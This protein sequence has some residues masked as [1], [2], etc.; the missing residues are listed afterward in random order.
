MRRAGMHTSASHT[1]SICIP[2]YR[3]LICSLF[4]IVVVAHIPLAANSFARGDVQTLRAWQV[5]QKAQAARRRVPT[6]GNVQTRCLVAGNQITCV[7]GIWLAWQAKAWVSRSFYLKR[8]LKNKLEGHCQCRQLAAL[9]FIHI[10]SSS[11]SYRS[12]IRAS[13]T[14]YLSKFV[15]LYFSLTPTL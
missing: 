15:Y 7:N 2:I 10:D 1:Y 11:S 3:T 13:T 12:T 4:V 6:L 14:L 8:E 5:L 9:E